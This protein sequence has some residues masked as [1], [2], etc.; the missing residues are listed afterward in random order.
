VRE[1][2]VSIFHREVVVVVV[3]VVWKGFGRRGAS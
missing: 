1:V 2:L 3:V